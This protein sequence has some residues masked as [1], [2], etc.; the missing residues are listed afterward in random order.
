LGLKQLEDDP[1]ATDIPSRFHPGDTVKGTVTKL[2]SFGAFVEISED[3]EGLLHISEMSDG[4]ID[5]P[6]EIV[7]PG[8]ALELKV[9]NVD[10][11]E[12]KIGLSLKALDELGQPITDSGPTEVTLASK[13]EDAKVKVKDEESQDE[14]KAEEKKEEPKAE[15]PKAEEPKTEPKAEA[16]EEEKPAEAEKKEEEKKDE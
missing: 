9:L 1:W 16:K 6:E 12:R 10:S 5:K 3:L 8:Q 13:L 15:E 7:Q 14:P 4:K 11:N 2:T